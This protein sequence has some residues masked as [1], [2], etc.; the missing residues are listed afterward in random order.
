[1]I[2][3]S[4]PTQETISLSPSYLRAKRIL[5]ITVTLLLLPV[6]CLVMALIA[7]VIRLDS[8]GPIFF[9]Q[10]R[11]GQNG[12]EFE[13]LKFR[14]MY[15]NNDDAAHRNA[16]E[17]F[18]QGERINTSANSSNHYK[19]VADRRIT[20]VGKFLRKTSLDELP[21]FLN[22]LSG[23]MS[24]VGPRPA[25]SYE[26]EFY[27]LHDRLRLTGK[28]GLTGIWQ[29]Y[30]RSRVPFKEMVEMD[31]TYLREQSLL[32]DLKLILLTVPVMLLARG[33]A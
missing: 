19:I 3:Q 15:V 31:L 29:V 23:E 14:S 8:E 5:D 24:L 17:Q 30:G 2:I 27:S 18:M 9:R 32:L 21:Q 25:L 16:I 4:A 10:K 33:G 13:F 11:L 6:L 1:M 20:R 22:V 12:S 26:V 28:P 7:L